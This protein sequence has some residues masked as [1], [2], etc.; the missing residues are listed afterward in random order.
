MP[1]GAQPA[2]G[3][4]EEVQLWGKVNSIDGSSP[5]ANGFETTETIDFFSD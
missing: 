2:L 3:H 5:D 4:V 1:N